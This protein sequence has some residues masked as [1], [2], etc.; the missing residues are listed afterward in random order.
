VS[1]AASASSICSSGARH[2]GAESI[3]LL[4]CGFFLSVYI[5]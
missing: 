3:G 1:P 2:G 5:R 4:F